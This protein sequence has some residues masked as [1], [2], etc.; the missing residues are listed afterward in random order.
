VATVVRSEQRVR[1]RCCDCGTPIVLTG[2]QARRREQQH[3]CAICIVLVHHGREPVEDRHRRY[4]LEHFSDEEI[5]GIASEMLGE[6]VPVSRV[7]ERWNRALL[8]V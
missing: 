4:W 7:Q 3:R 8:G 6:E 2:R 1:V 5:A